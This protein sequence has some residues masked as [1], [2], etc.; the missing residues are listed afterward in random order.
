MFDDVFI[1]VVRIFMWGLFCLGVFM[2][3]AHLQN[4]G[5][6]NTKS[7]DVDVLT[8]A[9]RRDIVCYESMDADSVRG[10]TIW[11]DGKWI[12]NNNIVNVV[13]K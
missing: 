6:F 2:L 10:D 4:T 8:Y 9:N 11:K 13:F 3:G 1:L 5:F 7:Y 12:V